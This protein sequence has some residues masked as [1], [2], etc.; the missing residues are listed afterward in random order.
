MNAEL[1][2]VSNW[3]RLNKLSLN[4]NKT[5]FII[6]RSKQHHIDYDVKIHLDETRLQPKDCVKYL[7]LYID[8]HLSWTAHITHLSKN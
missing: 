4:A 3:L 2:L 1:K 8:N 6:F 7:G 5:E